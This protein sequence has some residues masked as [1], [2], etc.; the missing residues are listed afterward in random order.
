MQH[1]LVPFGQV[2][3]AVVGQS[4]ADL[5]VFGEAGAFDGNDL[6][7]FGFD[8]ADLG[9][10]CP[11]GGVNSAVASKDAIVFVDDHGTGSAVPLKRFLDK[12]CGPIGALASVL[13]VG[14]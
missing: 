7:A 8:D 3:C 12:G 4:K 9:D 1:L 2:G 5:L 6:V 14:P 10:A 13:V 11:F